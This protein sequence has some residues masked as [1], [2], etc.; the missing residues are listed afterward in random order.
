MPNIMTKHIQSVTAEMAEV[1]SQR[2]ESSSEPLK[3]QREKFTQVGS[4]TVNGQSPYLLDDGMPSPKEP[5]GTRETTSQSNKDVGIERVRELLFG[6][7]IREQDKRLVNLEANSATE[8]NSLKSEVSSR[9]ASLENYVKAELSALTDLTLALQKGL[10]ETR[11]LLQSESKAHDERLIQLK[12][13]SETELRNAFDSLSKSKLEKSAFSELL[14]EI[15][16]RVNDEKQ[17]LESIS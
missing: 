14:C 17:D 16:L 11:E 13:D 7:K 3:K 6:S 1:M 9:I 2:L 8:I 15:A 12:N 4:Q 10:K 5:P